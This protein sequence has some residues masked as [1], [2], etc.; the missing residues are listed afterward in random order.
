MVAVKQG[1]SSNSYCSGDHHFSTLPG[2]PKKGNTPRQ[3]EKGH[4]PGAC[5]LSVTG[6]SPE[7]SNK[8]GRRRWVRCGLHEYLGEVSCQQTHS[9]KGRNRHH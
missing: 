3:Q 4:K 2:A 1:T 9:D 8:K 6:S 5:V 7:G